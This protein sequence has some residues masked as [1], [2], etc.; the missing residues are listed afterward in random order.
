MAGVEEHYS[1]HWLARR[2]SVEEEFSKI[3]ADLQ[4][5]SVA[6][7]ILLKT[8]LELHRHPHI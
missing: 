4:G 8:S 6:V 7:Q 1:A 3:W 5:C 2:D